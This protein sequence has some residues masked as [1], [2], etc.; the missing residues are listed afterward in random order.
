M[1]RRSSGRWSGTGV[2]V[3]G[4]RGGALLVGDPLLDFLGKAAPMRWSATNIGCRQRLRAR[5]RPGG[6][7]HGNVGSRSDQPDDPAGL[8]RRWDLRSCHRSG[9]VADR[10]VAFRS[11]DI[12]HDV[13]HR[14]QLSGPLR[15]FYYLR[16]C[17]PRPSHAS[18]SGRGVG[19]H[20]QGRAAGP[21]TQLAARGM[22]LPRP[23]HH[24]TVG[25][26]A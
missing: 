16:G 11:A 26:L 5:H 4:F 25:N 1:H 7:V 14:Y 17:W 13:D 24:R 6:R 18:S 10:F 19:R 22:E 12:Y 20:P 8:T 9:R 2:D 15:L 3:M 21:C 23:Q